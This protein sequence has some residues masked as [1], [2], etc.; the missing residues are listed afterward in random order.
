MTKRIALKCTKFRSVNFH[1]RSQRHERPWSAKE[2]SWFKDSLNAWVKPQSYQL[3]N[4]FIGWSW[5]K[6][7]HSSAQLLLSLLQ[8]CKSL[9][10]LFDYPPQNN[11]KS[12]VGGARFETVCLLFRRG[13]EFLGRIPST[14]HFGFIPI[15]YSRL[16]WLNDFFKGL[17]KL[18]NEQTCL[19]VQN[20]PNLLS[21]ELNWTYNE[22][23]FRFLTV[24]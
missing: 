24:P 4:C 10:F 6:S 1:W 15:N 14:Y 9:D 7:L 22:V 20:L 8:L 11:R 5:S 13:H 23:F 3:P 16:S 18:P 19:F 17:P 2:E 21:G 12:F